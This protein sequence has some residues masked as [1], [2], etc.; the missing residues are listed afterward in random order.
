MLCHNVNSAAESAYGLTVVKGILGL[1]PFGHFAMLMSPLPPSGGVR[2]SN[3]ACFMQLCTNTRSKFDMGRQ[4]L[5]TH[6]YVPREVE[7]S[8]MYHTGSKVV[9]H[10]HEGSYCTDSLCFPV[11]S[12]SRTRVP[13]ALI[14]VVLCQVNVKVF[15]LLSIN[16]TSHLQGLDCFF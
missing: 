9:Y 8:S 13:Q 10:S 12:H 6:P 2:Q 3:I 1:Q 5:P 11:N 15:C 7:S 14:P 4:L 16:V